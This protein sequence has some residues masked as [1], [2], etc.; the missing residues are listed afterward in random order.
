MGDLTDQAKGNAKEAVGKVTGDEQMQREGR[1]ESDAATAERKVDG[2][3]QEVIG[4]VQEGVGKVTGDRSTELAGKAKQ[5]E[6][7]ARRSV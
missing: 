1:L 6:S 5:V 7:E 3:A 4:K 2:T